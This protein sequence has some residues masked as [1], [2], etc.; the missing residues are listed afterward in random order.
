M[1]NI[2]FSGID[3][4][5]GENPNYTEVFWRGRDEDLSISH[6]EGHIRVTVD[7]TEIIVV[8]KE[9]FNMEVK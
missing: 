7:Y 1:L 3:E 5:T 2:L 9:S 8:T 6:L 4:L